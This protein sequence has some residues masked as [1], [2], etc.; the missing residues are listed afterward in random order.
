MI[1]KKHFLNETFIN[2]NVSPALDKFSF[3]PAN[4]KSMFKLEEISAA[5]VRKILSSLT[6]KNSTG[7][8]GISYRLL[9]EAGPGVAGP[10][11]TLFNI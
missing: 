5:D 2:Q 6:N 10:L 3:G 11:T 1:K 7:P 4:C 8:D 9:K